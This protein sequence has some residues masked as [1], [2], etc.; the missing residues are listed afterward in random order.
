[1]EAARPARWPQLS[2]VTVC[3]RRF[4]ISTRKINFAPL[5]YGK[6]G[7]DEAVLLQLCRD[8]CDNPPRARATLG[9]LIE[10][11]A[12]GNAF[13]ALLSGIARLEDRGL[14][15]VEFVADG[16]SGPH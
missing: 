2:R 7:D 3:C 6:I 13:S 10:E 12:I 16:V 1:M 4:L 9:L 15:R 11:E 8:A 14:G 5:K